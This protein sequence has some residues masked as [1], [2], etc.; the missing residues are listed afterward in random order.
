MNAVLCPDCGAANLPG[1]EECESCSTPLS[2]LATP[3]GTEGL[4]KR[5][6]SGTLKDLAPRPAVTVGPEATVEEAVELMRKHKFGCVLVLDG[7]RLAG[8]MTERDI[9]YGIAGLR[10]PR[11]VRVG[12]VMHTDPVCLEAFHP[13][14]YA[15]HHM[16]VGGYRHVPVL[17]EGGKL[18][19][20]SS[21]DLLRY[22]AQ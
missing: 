20:V 4:A 21:R 12:Q 17:L 8:V 6:L 22:L 18:G 9:L 1:A 19:I 15:F 13:V 5:I 14:S 16:A 2:D 11:H 7:G 3:Q 10:D